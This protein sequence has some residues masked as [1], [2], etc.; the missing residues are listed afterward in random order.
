MVHES[1]IMYLFNKTST[2]NRFIQLFKL[3]SNN[4]VGNKVIHDY[5][6]KIDNS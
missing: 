6:H 3:T 2:N 4:T 5:A 1:F